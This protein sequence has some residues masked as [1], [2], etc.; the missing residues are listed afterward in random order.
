MVNPMHKK[1]IELLSTEF[2]IGTPKVGSL[3]HIL[4]LIS[5]FLIATILIAALWKIKNNPKTLFAITLIA[6]IFLILL[7]FLKQYY[8]STEATKD[9]FKWIFQ[10][11][12]FPATL[13]AMP[14]YFLPIYLFTFKTK[15]VKM[16]VQDFLGIFMLFGGAFVLF[17]PGEIFKA[18]IFWTMHSVLFHGVMLIFG[19]FLVVTNIVAYKW[20]SVYH[21]FIVFVLLWIFVGAINE[22]LWQLKQKNVLSEIP[23]FLSI[24]HRLPS[25]YII[26]ISKFLKG[27]TLPIYSIYFIYPLVVFVISNSLFLIFGFIGFTIRKLIILNKKQYISKL[28]YNAYLRHINVIKDYKL[29]YSRN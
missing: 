11:W 15:K 19:L 5:C 24:S 10:P 1:I 25:P 22:I 6:L 4:I 23:N 8:F 9:K 3:F 16:Y 29:T 28:K 20:N 12:A 14:L 27:K 13:C 26:S 2:K 17:Y 7:E 21:A 18:N